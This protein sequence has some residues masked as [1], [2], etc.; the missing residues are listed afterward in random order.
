MQ[1]DKKNIIWL[2]SYPKSGNTWF[3]VFLSNLLL[4]SKEPVSIN[5]LEKTPIAS[6]R[7]IFDEITGLS[8]GELSFEETDLLRPDVYREYANSEDG[9]RFLKVHD[10]YTFLPDGKPMIPESVTK[11]AIFFIRNPLDVAVSFAHHSS[12]STENM[13]KAMNNTNYAFC[14]KTDRIHNQLRQKLLT[15]SE[16]VESWTSNIPFPVLVL[17][18]EEMLD[19]TYE[20]FEKAVKFIGLEKNRQQ[21]EKALEF[22]RFD[23][24]KSQEEKEGFKEKAPDAEKFFRKGKS[25]SWKSELSG[26]LAMEIQHNH[27]EVMKKYG[28]T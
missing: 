13:V 21:I 4:D 10:A 7:N 16:H 3:R 18:Y 1:K 24:L 22:S 6:A 15:W 23:V 5:Q 14:S 26:E 28:Y 11:S 25:G 8:S 2:A 20:T 9:L 12:S 17:K 19:N 27:A